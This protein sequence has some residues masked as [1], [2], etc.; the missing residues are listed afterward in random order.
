MALGFKLKSAG[1][2]HPVL[3]III[4]PIAVVAQLLG[5]PAAHGA[6]FPM[7]IV[8]KGGVELHVI[9]LFRRV[10][11]GAGAPV[12]GI[13]LFPN[14]G[15]WRGHGLAAFRQAV[16]ADAALQVVLFIVV[17]PVGVRHVGLLAAFGAKAAAVL[18]AVLPVGIFVAVPFQQMRF[19]FV[20][21]HAADGAIV[22]VLVVIPVH[23]EI[24]IVR[25]LERRI[26]PAADRALGPVV[27]A[28]GFP[29]GHIMLAKGAFHFL[30]AH[31]A[32][33][34]VGD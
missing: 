2:F 9:L 3:G 27:I 30:A 24:A 17:L 10:A 25:F 31:F 22:P 16:A 12:P 1:A 5:T 20:A 13:V 23:F 21:G 7:A 4:S 14:R 8:V 6:A 34:H 28:V 18:F 32:K 11:A 29:E 33:L 15:V 26:L 19:L